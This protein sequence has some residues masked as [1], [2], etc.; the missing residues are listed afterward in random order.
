MLQVIQSNLHQ[1]FNRGHQRSVKAKKNIIQSVF[2]KGGSVIITLTLIP[3]TINYINPTQY[4]MW[5]TLSSLITW[6]ALFDMGLGNGLKNKLAEFIALDDIPTARSYVSSTYAILVVI[7]LLLFIVFYFVNPYISWSRILNVQDKGNTDLNRLVLIIFAFFC[8]QFVVQ[9]INTV[10]TANQAPA[11]FAFLNLIAQV[12]TLIAVVGLIRF[13]KQGSLT[14]LV[15]I[16]AGV[17]LIALLIGSIWF[18][19]GSYKQISPAISHINFKHA[20]ELL[21]VGGGFFIIQ[22]SALVFYETDNIV[23]TQLFGPKEV[24]TFNV[25]YKLFSI[26]LMLFVIVITP[27]WS[28]FTEAYV[29]NDYEWIKN[30]ISKINKL[31]IALSFCTVALLMVSPV[32]YSL[33]LGKSVTVPLV[34]SIAMCLY[35]ITNIWQAIYVQLLNGIGKIKL[36]LYLTTIGAIINIPLAVVLGKTF[37]VAGVTLANAILFVVMGIVFYVQ[38]GKIINK[39]ATGIFNA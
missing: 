10:L 37:G 7:S 31:W 33:W 30:A 8:L 1:F 18:Y 34:L 11:K 14:D 25:A 35:T 26:V 22:I 39:T 29:K 19:R 27:F 28:A 20:R 5:L 4:G 38:A 23:I 24:T 6:A 17:P 3:L 21:S 13:H 32:I 15:I 12:L 16:I 36:Q 9:L 2:L